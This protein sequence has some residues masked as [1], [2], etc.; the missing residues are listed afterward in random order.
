MKIKKKQKITVRLIKEGEF[1]EKG[2]KY[3]G[4]P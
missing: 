2:I 3:D 1:I 4:R